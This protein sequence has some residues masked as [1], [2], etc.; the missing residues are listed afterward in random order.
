MCHSYDVIELLSKQITC[1]WGV[2]IPICTVAKIIK[3]DHEMR[4][5]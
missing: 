3:I 4:E 1:D 2:Y 5:L